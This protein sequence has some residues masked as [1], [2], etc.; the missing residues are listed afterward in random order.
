MSASLSRSKLAG[1]LKMLLPNERSPPS[2]HQL[3]RLASWHRLPRNF[4]YRLTVADILFTFADYVSLPLPPSLPLLPP[5]HGRELVSVE[6][7][8]LSRFCS[9]SHAGGL[10]TSAESYTLNHSFIQGRSRE[11]VTSRVVGQCRSSAK[12]IERNVSLANYVMVK[13]ENLSISAS[14]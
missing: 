3:L 7:A 5:S 13:Q 4:L 14:L 2:L 12:A 11:N 1:V 8:A 9:G 6:R 10:M